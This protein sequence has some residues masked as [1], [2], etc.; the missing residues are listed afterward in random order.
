MPASDLADRPDWLRA[1]ARLSGWCLAAF[2]VYS[3]L[4]PIGLRPESGAPPDIE[5][6]GAF[7]VLSLAFA[8]GYPRSRQR[9]AL[10]LMLAAVLLELA[11]GLSPSR[12][13]RPAD[14]AFKV[15]GAGSGALVAWAWDVF[16][17]YLGRSARRV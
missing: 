11:Q 5:R 6:F 9:V 15:L 4:S 1:C 17:S 14:A 2:I 12:H 16:R 10:A 8:L 7:F 3:T 13:G